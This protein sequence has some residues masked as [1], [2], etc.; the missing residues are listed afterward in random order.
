MGAQ[1]DGVEA[2][3]QRLVDRMRSRL[4]TGYW[5]RV[6]CMLIVTIATAAAC[7][8]SFLLL[9]LRIH[10]MAF[11]YGVA[12]LAG[13]VTFLLLLRAWVRWRWARAQLNA[14]GSDIVDAAVNN[15]D[16]PLPSLSGRGGGGFG[17]GGGRSGGGGASSSWGT[18][19]KSVSSGGGKGGGGGG[20]DL[21]GDDLFWVIVV[22]VAAFGGAIA[23][24]YVIWIA[25][26]LLAEAIVNGAVAGKVYHGM[27]KKD[28]EFW[29]EDIFKRTIVA[30]AVVIVCAIV[31]G[32]ALNRIAPEAAS[33]GGVWAH[34]L[35]R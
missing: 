6:H 11:R 28:H 19:V 35:S 29:T 14:D 27:Q 17:G 32:Y 16:L 3:R 21:D 1:P 2:S 10:S 20:L 34:V 33:V 15:V 23:I 9:L 24:G 31:A 13:Y 25:P 26:T 30:G 5:P 22:V 8:T 12:A 4:E 7:L 18:P